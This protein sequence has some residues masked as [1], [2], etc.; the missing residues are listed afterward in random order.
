L[1]DSGYGDADLLVTAQ[2]QHQVDVV[3]P[4]FGSYSRQHQTGQG[5]D[6]QAFVLDWDAQQ[7]RCP[8]G[9]TSVHW[10]PGHDV[11]G[12][13]VIRIRFDGPTCRACPA[14]QACTA[15][16]GAPRQLTVRLQTHHEA[17]QAARQRQDTAEFKAQYALRAG[18]ESSLSQ[19]TRRFDL[20][21]S[22]S[23]GLA[24]TH[25]QQLLTATAMNL[26]RVIAWLWGEPLDEH[27]RP[28]GHLAQLSPHP[29]SRQTV[30]C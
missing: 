26:V 24:R 18:V 8:Q 23:I 19:G 12:D 27:R 4:A 16:K 11:S 3:G 22:R 29:L 1:L 14:R 7:A 25:L 15:A 10:R 30:L 9:H 13:P 2:T 21:R 20:R 5:Y 6:L 17:I 28:P